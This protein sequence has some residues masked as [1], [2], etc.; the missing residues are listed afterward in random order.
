MQHIDSQT[1]SS[2]RAL[3]ALSDAVVEHC[4]FEGEED[5]ESPLKESKNITVISSFCDLRYPFWH[6]DGITL[7]DVTLTENCRAALWYSR[8]VRVLESRLHG[9][10]ALRECEDCEIRNADVRSAE[11]GWRCRNVSVTDSSLT[12]EYAFFGAKDV[13]LSGVHFTGKYSFQYCENV[14][15]ENC[16]LETKDA[17]WNTKNVVVKDSVVKGEYLAWYAE[18]ITFVRCRIIGTQPL[19]YCKG[20]RIIDCS[21]ENCDLSFEYSEVEAEILGHVDSVKN[22]REG[23]IVADSFGEII[24]T[25]DA[26]YPTDAEVVVR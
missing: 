18:N 20:L 17:F 19:C 8:G 11:F 23:K 24:F 21:M 22:P 9:I 5:G 16:V 3:Y 4:R 10:K 6:D 13:T 7:R 15:V 1:Y 25:S 26:V 12:G 14:T 2:E